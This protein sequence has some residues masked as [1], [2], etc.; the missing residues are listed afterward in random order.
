M[1]A[2][3]LGEISVERFLGGECYL[4]DR[5]RKKPLRNGHFHL[6]KVSELVSIWNVS[7]SAKYFINVENPQMKVTIVFIQKFDFVFL[8]KDKDFFLVNSGCY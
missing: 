6:S 4:N 8:Q 5:K 2:R 3:I 7:G 1:E